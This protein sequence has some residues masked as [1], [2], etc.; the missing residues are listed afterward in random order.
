MEQI[1]YKTMREYFFTSY[2]SFIT[3]IMMTNKQQNTYNILILR[4]LTEQNLCNINIIINSGYN[5]NSESYHELKSNITLNMEEAY[6]LINDIRNDFKD[7]HY[8]SY[9]AINPKNLIQVLQNTRFSLNIKLLNKEEYEDAMNFNNKINSN[10]S[11]HKAL[12]IN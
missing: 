1:D 11:R 4:K 10:K 2:K 7:N 3:C 8:I 9:S 5:N 12:K 6:N